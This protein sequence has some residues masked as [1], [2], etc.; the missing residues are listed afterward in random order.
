MSLEALRVALETSRPMIEQ[1]L[2]AAEAERDELR[3]RCRELDSL[4]ARAK[5]ALGETEANTPQV[6]YERTLRYFARQATN[7]GTAKLPR[8]WAPWVAICPSGARL[9]RGAALNPAP[10]SS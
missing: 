9:V 6:R 7:G 4:I 3:A 1:A 10:R 2:A 8:L 5:A